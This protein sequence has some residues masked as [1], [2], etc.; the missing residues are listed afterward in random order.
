MLMPIH[1]KLLKALF[2]TLLTPSCISITYGHSNEEFLARY[3]LDDGIEYH[4]HLKEGRYYHPSSRDRGGHL[5]ST[6]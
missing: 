5:S 3:D 6:T 4:S 2:I 1:K